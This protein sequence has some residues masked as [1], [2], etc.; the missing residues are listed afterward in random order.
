MKSFDKKK[1]NI[2]KK[3]RIA[4]GEERD[5]RN[6]CFV[7]DELRQDYQRVFDRAESEHKKKVRELRERELQK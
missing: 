1:T 4:S 5:R 2:H 6:A 7:L 3:V